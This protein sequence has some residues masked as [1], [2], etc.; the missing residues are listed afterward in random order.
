MNY[1][2]SGFYVSLL[3]MLLMVGC[4][5]EA[6]FEEIEEE[7]PFQPEVVEVED[8]YL[9]YRLAETPLYDDE[10]Y[11]VV[12]TDS[13]TDTRIYVVASGEVICEGNG[14]A[15]YSIA[16]DPEPFFITFFGTEER[17]YTAVNSQFH[18]SVE[19]QRNIA[20]LYGK[21][22]TDPCD[23][24]S[25]AVSID[26]VSEDRIEGSV[27][28]TAYSWSPIIEPEEGQEFCEI[29]ESMGPFTANF[30]ISLKPCSF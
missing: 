16:G 30:A 29:L 26:R 22:T 8:N 27:T 21:D 4:Q 23:P 15:S 9:D 19:G 13:A 1:L 6:V 28:G 2:T 24:A 12:F 17:G 3:A 14:T 20:F 18:L 5:E 11:G 10:G 7:L 25:A